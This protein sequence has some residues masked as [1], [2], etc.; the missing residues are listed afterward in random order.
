MAILPVYLK[1]L[2]AT[3]NSSEN[4]VNALTRIPTMPTEVTSEYVNHYAML[5]ADLCKSKGADQLHSNMSV[6]S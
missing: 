4:P 1:F 2:P 5:F 6:N 3:Q